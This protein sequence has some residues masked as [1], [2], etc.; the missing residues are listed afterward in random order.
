MNIFSSTRISNTSLAGALFIVL[1]LFGELSSAATWIDTPIGLVGLG[2]VAGA[3]SVSGLTTKC[4]STNRAISLAFVLVALWAAVNLAHTESVMGQVSGGY[5]CFVI[6]LAL[7][8]WATMSRF[9]AITPTPGVGAFL[10][11]FLVP[12]LF[13]VWLIVLWE[14]IT[15]GL[16]IPRVLLPPPSLVGEA[17]ASSLGVLAADFRQTIIRAVLPGF[18]MGNLAGFAIALWADR[19]PFLRRGLL[20]VGNLVSAIPI[21]GIA[22][23]MVMWFGFDW[24]SKAAVVVIMTFFPMLVNT[25]AG[26][27]GSSAIELDLM[28]SIGASHWQ[29]FTR[30]R[31][32]NALPFIFNALKINSALALIGAIVAEFFGTPIVGIGFRI[33]TEAGRMNMEM[34][35]A[36]IAL[37]AVSGSLFYGL[38]AVV[39]R[40]ATFWHPSFRQLSAKRL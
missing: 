40:R 24:Q 30:V 10:Y 37:S 21:V 18:V 29:T 31:L 11:Q 22:P 28:R 5:W 2:C 19:V 34:V 35:W 27:G 36:S 23:I 8:I 1:G 32:P 6:A 7:A 26:L 4:S 16:G 14:L 38:L 33:S 25:V 3:L 39:E 15:V 17:I 13:G 20:P 9:A 12:G